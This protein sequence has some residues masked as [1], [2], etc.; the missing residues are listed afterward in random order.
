MCLYS[1]RFEM[2]PARVL[3]VWLLTLLL[4]VALPATAQSDTPDIAPPPAPLSMHT[5]S[6]VVVNSVTGEPVRRALV[7]AGSSVGG[8]QLSVLTDAEGRFEFPA[9]PESDIVMT[10]RKP[11]FFGDLELHPE[12]YQPDILHLSADTP[13]LVLKL[14]PESTVVGHVA[15]VKG[16]PIEDMPVRLL[17]EHIVDG[18]KKWELRGQAI[19]DEDGQFRVSDLV[20]GQYL[21]AAGPRLP[22]AM[23]PVR[24]LRSAREEGF[25]TIFYPGVPEL[26]A[27]TPLAITGGQ[28]WQADFALKAEPLFKVSGLVVGLAPGIGAALQFMNKAGE[29]VSA[30]VAFDIQ[31]GKFEVRIPAGSYLLQLRAS[32]PSGQAAVADS[33]LIVN[34]DVEGLSLVLGPPITI[35]VKVDL[36]ATGVPV[37]QASV[38]SL[39]PKN[40][41]G[42]SSLRLISTGNRIQAEEFMADAMEKGGSIAVHN[43]S[44]GH[45]SVEIAPIPPWYVRSVTSGTTDLLRDDLV[46]SS[47]H[48]PD[49][50]EVVLRDDCAGVHGT[51]RV[52][53]QPA[54]GAVLLISDQMSPSHA[55]AAVVPA[56]AEF[57]FAGIAP[58]EYKLLA[59]DSIDDLEFR[60]P[61]V[62]GPYLSKAVSVTLEPNEVAN[63][64]V[65]RIN[66]GK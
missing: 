8:S 50:L 31:S 7:Q 44:P 62:L 46:I 3:A 34:G 18:R 11:G 16:E 52:D 12:T 14:L 61:D 33:P 40:T 22:D 64:N 38:T 9:L 42:L 25:G 56:S 47:G 59:F 27:A 49:P 43:V 21:L 66:R 39:G 19:T 57:L 54:G 17:Q 58:G 37:P 6:G 13:S 20:P 2:A 15:T 32:D 63:I 4:A 55:Q 48:R 10:A 45:Y 35:P 1:E 23:M 60:N 5:L 30:P 28:Q 26:G 36:R 41:Q 24:R 65:E 29:V 53:G 51:I